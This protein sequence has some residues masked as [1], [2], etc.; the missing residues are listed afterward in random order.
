MCAH[1]STTK[2]T[3]DGDSYTL[4]SGTPAGPKTST[5]KSG[6]EMDDVIGDDNMAVSHL[7]NHKYDF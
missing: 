3:K 7:K 6:V 5:F 1:K 2:I 4:S